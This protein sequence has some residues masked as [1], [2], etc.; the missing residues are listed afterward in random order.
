MKKQRF[1]YVKKDNNAVK[2]QK[3]TFEKSQKLL[4][5]NL[6]EGCLQNFQYIIAIDSVLM[7]DYVTAAPSAWLLYVVHAQPGRR[8]V[9]VLFAKMTF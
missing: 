4:P 6:S 1:A 8:E 7:A 3:V 2:S 5:E 9:F